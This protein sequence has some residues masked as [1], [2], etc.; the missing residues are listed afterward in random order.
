MVW[1]ILSTKLRMFW[2]TW[3]RR[4][5]QVA[6]ELG[7]WRTIL[8][9]RIFSFLW[10]HK[11]SVRLGLQPVACFTLKCV[12]C[13]LAVICLAAPSK[14][15]HCEKWRC[16]GCQAMHQFACISCTSTQ[17]FKPQYQSIFV[18]GGNGW[19]LPIA[20]KIQKICTMPFG[21]SKWFPGSFVINDLGREMPIEWV[22]L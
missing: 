19:Q 22:A 3:E 20:V 1:P 18:N 12:I 11:G 16:F 6:V 13:L 9:G 14:G 5:P 10:K 21:K 4:G 17:T 8:F 2:F 7:L 15:L